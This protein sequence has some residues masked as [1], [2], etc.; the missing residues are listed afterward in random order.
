MLGRTTQALGAAGLIAAVSVIPAPSA[1]AATASAPAAAA[2]G[3]VR[4]WEDPD[5]TGSLYVQ[6]TPGQCPA[7]GCDI[8]GWDGDNEISSVIN[9]TNCTVRLW[10]LDGF[11]GGYVDLGPGRWGNLE[12]QGFDNKA[13]S[14]TFYC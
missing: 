10:D 4:M 14:Y 6:T 7:E 1:F 13:E 11:A 2:P 5:Y 3:E 8:D 12:L 9:E